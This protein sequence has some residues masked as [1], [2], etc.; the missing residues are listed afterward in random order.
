MNYN[1]KTVYEGQGRCLTTH[2]ASG[3]KF[4]TDLHR[5]LG[6]LEDNPAPAELLGATL[7][8][9]MMSLVSYLAGRKDIDVKGMSIEAQPVTKGLKITGFNLLITMPLSSNHPS[10]QALEQSAQTCPVKQAL[11]PSIKITQEWKWIG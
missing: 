5:D 3:K 10:R 8:S 2:I 9:C 1:T 11:D 4:A 7:A 6:G